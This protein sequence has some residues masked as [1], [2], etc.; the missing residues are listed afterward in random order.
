MKMK[1]NKKEVIHQKEQY[2]VN[3][4]LICRKFQPSKKT[5]AILFFSSADKK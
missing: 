2:R 1:V 4:M 5:I 3:F